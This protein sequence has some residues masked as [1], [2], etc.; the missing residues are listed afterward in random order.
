MGNLRHAICICR[1]A[2]LWKSKMWRLS[3]FAL[4]PTP[5][6]ISDQPSPDPDPDP[7]DKR[8]LLR[9]LYEVLHEV[10]TITIHFHDNLCQ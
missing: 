7:P 3:F 10:Q 1:D 5:S 6:N 2:S 4:P 8:E 9:T